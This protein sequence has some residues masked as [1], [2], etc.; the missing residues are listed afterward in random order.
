MV[1]DEIESFCCGHS[2]GTFRASE[3][4]SFS[5]GISRRRSLL[6]LTYDADWDGHQKEGG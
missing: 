4:L 3:A 5:L 2:P 6:H 1:L